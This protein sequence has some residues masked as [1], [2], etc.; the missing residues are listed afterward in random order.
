MVSRIINPQKP[1]SK[2]EKPKR[3]KRDDPTGRICVGCGKVISETQMAGMLKL[4]DPKDPKKKKF[5]PSHLTCMNRVLEMARRNKQSW[6]GK[7]FGPAGMNRNKDK[8][9][10]TQEEYM[11]RMAKNQNRKIT[12]IKK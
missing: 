5:T 8:K 4:S 11:I 9:L 10:E 7:D 3:K 12:F 1:E 2:E 6:A